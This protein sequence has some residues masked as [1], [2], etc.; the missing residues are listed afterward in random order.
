MTRRQISWNCAIWTAITIQMMTTYNGI[1]LSICFSLIPDLTDTIWYGMVLST[2]KKMFGKNLNITAKSELNQPTE[3]EYD[4]MYFQPK[5]GDE[6]PC[7]SQIRSEV[8]VMKN[9]SA[10]QPMLLLSQF[11]GNQLV[12]LVSLFNW[13]KMNELDHGYIYK[14]EKKNARKFLLFIVQD[15]HWC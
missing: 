14:V 1:E 5:F 8:L 15:Y 6:Y 10:F 12:S 4:F 11:Y 2:M 3:A 7:K 13:K 9:C